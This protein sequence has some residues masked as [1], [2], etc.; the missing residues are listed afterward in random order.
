MSVKQKIWSGLLE[1]RNNDK[2]SIRYIRKKHFIL[3]FIMYL[4]D[5]EQSMEFLADSREQIASQEKEGFND[6][7]LLMWLKKT[8]EEKPKWIE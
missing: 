1:D 4:L 8:F 3:M 6:Y 5:N 7:S 2:E